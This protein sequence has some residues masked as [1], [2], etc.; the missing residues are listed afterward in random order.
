MLFGLWL[1]LYTD[2]PGT[3]KCVSAH[4]REQ[5]LRGKSS[6]EIEMHGYLPYKYFGIIEQLGIVTLHSEPF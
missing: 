4:E 3:H 6:A 2:H 5:I 1:L